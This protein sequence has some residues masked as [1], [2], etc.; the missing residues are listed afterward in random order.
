MS[1]IK[2]SIAQMWHKNHSFF[3]AVVIAQMTAAFAVLFVIGAAANDYYRINEDYRTNMSL[4]I[5]FD[6]AGEEAVHYSDLKET[7]FEI[8]N[9]SVPGEIKDVALSTPY[10][11]DYGKIV[12]VF[13]T[14]G[15]SYRLSQ[16]DIYNI[17]GTLAEG[18]LYTDEEYNS[19]KYY[20]LTM[21][22]DA[23]ELII[24]G[25]KFEV[26]GKM[27]DFG[28]VPEVRTTP[29]VFEDM[30]LPIE[31]LCFDV[32]RILTE[33]ELGKVTVLLDKVIPGK[34]TL[35]Y[36]LSSKEDEKAILRS[37][38]LISLIIGMSAAA[39][40]LIVY[41]YIMKMRRRNLAIWRLTG[42]SALRSAG[43]FFCEMAVISVPSVFSGFVFFYAAQRLWLN[44]LYPYMEV[45]HTLGLYAKV[46]AAMMLIMFALFAALAIVNSRHSVKEQLLRAN[47]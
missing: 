7:V 38:I 33:K 29:F 26:L 17:G 27:L 6:K 21:S 22:I 19:D 16:I 28:V 9:K 24:E 31:F 25:K 15:D 5:A 14:D 1:I 8:C 35:S 41:G 45:T 3:I 12:S 43:L 39:V 46:Y 34:Y 18:R 40:L 4:Y 10:N 13:A 23:D 47:I 37:S 30:N 2:S 42:C 36:K 32:N 44:E 20:A 11:E